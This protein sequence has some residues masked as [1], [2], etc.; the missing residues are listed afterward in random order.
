MK[1]EIE[2]I[3]YA[4]E[5]FILSRKAEGCTERTIALYKVNIANFKKFLDKKGIEKTSEIS[6]TII[7]EFLAEM[8]ERNL[9]DSYV[10]LYART[11]KTLLRFCVEDEII[12]KYPKFQMPKI[13]KKQ[14]CVLDID[15]VKKVIKACITI[16]DKAI[17]YLAVD[18]GLRL[19]EIVSL[20]WGDVHFDSGIITVVKGKGRKFRIVPASPTVLRLLKKYGATLERTRSKDPVFQTDAGRLTNWGLDSVFDRLS[21]RSGVDF[22]AHALRRTYAK[23]SVKAGLGVIQIQRNMGH[24]NIQ[25]TE[26]Y[27]QD[28]DD[29]DVIENHKTHS[30]VDNFLR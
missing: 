5:S 13:V 25:T 16:R 7:R 30:V 9:S 1:N 18:T 19:S 14:K 2:T 29:D 23:M 12:D 27:I 20:N 28:L 26:L 21:E 22:S 11:I 4:T 8:I 3:E 24:S 6:S 15:C 10:H 17:V